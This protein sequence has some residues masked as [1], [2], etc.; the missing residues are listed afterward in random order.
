MIYSFY[1]ADNECNNEV[2][3]LQYNML[4][5]VSHIFDKITFIICHNGYSN[6]DVVKSGK[7]GPTNFQTI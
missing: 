7:I 1:I 2:Y 3:E 4:S 6:D 5:Q